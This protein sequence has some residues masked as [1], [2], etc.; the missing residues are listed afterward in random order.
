VVSLALLAPQAR[1]V[2]I[3]RHL[4]TQVPAPDGVTFESAAR[5][6][7]E[8]ARWQTEVVLVHLADHAVGPGKK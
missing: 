3:L 4:A 8:L 2:E 1:R 6:A 7:D 5:S